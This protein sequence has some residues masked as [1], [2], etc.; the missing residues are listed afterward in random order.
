MDA[1]LPSQP[2]ERGTT[3]LNDGRFVRAWENDGIHAQVFNADGSA[4]GAAVEVATTLPFWAANPTIDMLADGRL[5]VS[6][7]DRK[8]TGDDPEDYAIRAQI[9]DPR[10]AAVSLHGTNLADHYIGTRWAD[11]LSGGAGNDTLI[12]ATGN[13]GLKGEDGN[14]SLLG[15]DGNDTIFGGN[16]NDDMQGDA[17]ADRLVGGAGNDK[18]AG[19]LGRDVM[20]GGL[21]ADTFIFASAA[22]IGNGTTRDIISDFQSGVDDIDLRALKTDGTFIGNAAFSGTAGEV[23]YLQTTGILSGDLN[24]DGVA[25][26]SLNITN[27]AALV[28]HDLLF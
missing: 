19:G 17:G 18:I 15:G 25:D 24:G 4:S 22:D 28:A 6:W 27:K 5:I 3:P 23:R 16:G 20:T 9:L 21:G 7:V 13:D 10:D 12:G 14:D 2:F 8:S 1:T 26:W 11:R